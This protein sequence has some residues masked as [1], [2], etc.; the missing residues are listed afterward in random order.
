MPVF[1]PR[2]EV[3]EGEV[4]GRGP[5]HIALPDIR[6]LNRCKQLGL[7]ALSL[8]VRPPLQAAAESII[9]GKVRLTP[10]AINYV[11]GPV[12]IRPIELGGDL[13][14]EMVKGE[15]LRQQIKSVFYRDLVALPDKNYMT[16]TEIVKQLDLIHRELGPDSRADSDGHAATVD[17]SRLRGHV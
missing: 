10:A 17:R 8:M 12:E 13:K 16:A 5:G 6:S 14:S 2:W 3:E 1:V 4:Y 11:N 15:E 9:G 7:E